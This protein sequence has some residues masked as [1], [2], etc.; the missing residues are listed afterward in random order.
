VRPVFISTSLMRALCL[1]IA[2]TTSLP[3]RQARRSPSRSVPPRIG[4]LAAAHIEGGPDLAKP[5]G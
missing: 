1:A 2:V 3:V 4:D 5:C